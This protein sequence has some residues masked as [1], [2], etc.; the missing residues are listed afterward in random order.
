MIVGAGRR[1]CAAIVIA[2]MI[3]VAAV[4]RAFIATVDFGGY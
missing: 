1:A 3:V 2:A 4:V